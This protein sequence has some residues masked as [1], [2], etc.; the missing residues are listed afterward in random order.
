MSS[1]AKLLEHFRRT[2][3]EP[4][5]GGTVDLIPKSRGVF[6]VATGLGQ[7]DHRPGTCFWDNLRIRVWKTEGQLKQT[8][9][10]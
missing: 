9:G 2:D 6:H 3:Q 7:W 10:G 1:S 8:W 5:N 4:R